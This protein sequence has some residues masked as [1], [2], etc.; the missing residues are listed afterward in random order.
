[1]VVLPH[2]GPHGIRDYWL[3]DQA[4]QL[5]A[6]RGYVVLQVNYRGSGGYGYSFEDAG[7]GNWGT[8]IQDDITDAARWAIAQGIADP[9]RI[10]IYGGSFG[11]YAALMSATSEPDL[12]RCAIG[13]AGV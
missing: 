6:S 11:G 13:L 2:G 4:G 10:C 8:K 3:W 12:Y 1:M 9:K 5:L 7:Y